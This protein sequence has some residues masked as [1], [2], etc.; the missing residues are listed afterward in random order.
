MVRP[1]VRIMKSKFSQV[2]Y[3]TESWQQYLLYVVD[4]SLLFLNF[5]P[6]II[7]IS[8]TLGFGKSE[9]L[10]FQVKTRS[11][12]LSKKSLFS[13]HWLLQLMPLN[14]N[15][16]VGFYSLCLLL[17]CFCFSLW[18]SPQGSRF[19]IILGVVTLSLFSKIERKALIHKIE[20]NVDEISIQNL[21]V[22]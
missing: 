3:I 2:G 13:W 7:A 15:I 4:T 16:A 19:S 8:R 20:Y 14:G 18:F 10:V 1:L 11:I 9:R 22:L 5:T 12:W 17:F 21:W 6:L